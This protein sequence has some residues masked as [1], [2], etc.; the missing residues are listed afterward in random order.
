MRNIA[1]P[2]RLALAQM[3]VIPGRPDINGGEIIEMIEAAAEKSADIIVFPEL[4][5]TGYFIGDMFEDECFLRDV[6]RVNADIARATSLS[7]GITAVLGTIVHSTGKKGEDGFPRVMNSAVVY[8]CGRYIGHN[9]KTLQPNY[10]MFEDDRHFFSTRKL[11]D[12]GKT[13]ADSLIEPVEIRL[14]SGEKLRLGVMLCEDMW[15]EHYSVKPARILASK[16]ADILFNIS[17]S[18][19]TWQ[20]NRKRHKVIK[21]LMEH[22]PVPFVYVNKVGTQ[23]N[24]KNIMIFDGCSAVY[25]G[26]GEQVFEAPAHEENIYEVILR[27]GMRTVPRKEQDDTKELFDA[28][29]SAVEDF[30][31]SFPPEQRK[32][33]AP[34]SGGIDSALSTALFTHVL[35]K[36]NVTGVNMPSKFNS[37]RT[38]SLAKT[39]ADNLGIAYEIRP[40]QDIVNITARAAGVN[41]NTLA[42]ENIQARAR[43]EILAAMA[44]SRNALF[45]ANWNKVEAAFGYGTLYGD[46]AGALAVIGDLLKR[47]VYQLAEYM[48]KKVFLHEVIPEDCFN[49]APSAELGKNQKDPFDYGRLETR[50]YHEEMV[51]AFTEFRKNPEWFADMYLKGSLETELKLEKGRLNKLF[52]NGRDFIIDLEKHWALFHNSFFK[53]I[54]STVIPIVSKR[55]FGND[56]RESRMSPHLTKRYFGLRSEILSKE[57]GRIVL[58]GGSFDPSSLH[59][60]L[61]AMRLIPWFEKVVII[62]CGPRKDKGSLA[63]TPPEMRKRMAELN[64]GDLPVEMDFSDIDGGK[65]TPEWELDEK[66]KKLYPDKE[67]WHAAGGDLVAG[68]AGGNSQIQSEWERGKD[69]WK[70]LNFAVILRAGFYASKEDLPP[71]SQTIG[72]PDLIGSGTRIRQMIASGDD[73]GEVLYPK[74]MEFIEKNGL[75]R[76]ENNADT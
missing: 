13:D 59:H 14:R 26:K 52:R 46:M 42:Y 25:S 41:E 39:I 49:I 58:F 16:G 1:R 54:Q 7:G 71:S 27:K 63:L 30:F 62:P 12:A 34:I 65:F 70:K 3:K 48:N 18:P 47:E 45:P 57:K 75:Y 73:V 11:A 22:S 74:V 29:V 32:L 53:R 66:Y 37:E 31:E 60:R 10:R 28:L 9:V 8:S 2:I 69:I 67:I 17:A 36:E 64:F 44:Q 50:G 40:I 56:L 23:N 4:A 76:R 68:G 5:T 38:R 24:G 61:I 51:R 15:D 33:I 35:G 21:D 6:E 19:W 72:I 43:M 20:K 55:A